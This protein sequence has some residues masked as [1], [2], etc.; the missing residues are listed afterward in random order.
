MYEEE[1]RIPGPMVTITFDLSDSSQEFTY[2]QM[3]QAEKMYGALTDIAD[4]LR[5]ISKHGAHPIE[6]RELSE[7]EYDLA[8]AIKDRFHDI[9][10]DNGVD[11]S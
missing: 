10:V 11:L 4:M 8:Y 3:K 7:A 6:P 2:D 5:S 1:N 9:I